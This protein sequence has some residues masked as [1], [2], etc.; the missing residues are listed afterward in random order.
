MA[1]VQS[2]GTPPHHS[3]HRELIRPENEGLNTAA[4]RAKL[5]PAA[6]HATHPTLLQRVLKRADGRATYRP[7]NQN[8]QVLD[9][10]R[11]AGGS[12]RA[13]PLH[14]C[15]LR[16]YWPSPTRSTIHAESHAVVPSLLAPLESV[17]FVN[18]NHHAPEGIRPIWLNPTGRCP[19]APLPRSAGAVGLAALL[20]S[21]CAIFASADTT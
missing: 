18:S 9:P 7:A 3:P 4:P 10:Q 16:R 1:V 19:E 12:Q 6:G 21:C 13:T 2:I 17:S 11:P 5:E 14:Y 15:C 20:I 8:A